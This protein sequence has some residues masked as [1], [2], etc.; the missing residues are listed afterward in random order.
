MLVDDSGATRLKSQAELTAAA[1]KIAGAGGGRLFYFW[2]HASAEDPLLDAVRGCEAELR[3]SQRELHAVLPSSALK[4]PAVV[5]QVAW[6][7]EQGFAVRGSSGL[8]PGAMLLGVEGALLTVRTGSGRGY[9][10]VEEAETLSVLA[11]FADLLWEGGDDL[12]QAGGELPT[13]V[14][15]RVL[16]MLSQGATDRAVAHQLGLSDRTVRR[17]VAQLTDRLGAQS[18]FEA[19]VRAVG[20]GWI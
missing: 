7:R 12:S 18:R 1:R 13:T 14:E 15:L 2:N 6:Q 8:P 9:V 4:T 16:R 19:G 3:G 17:V 20:R 10:R 5:E 11:A